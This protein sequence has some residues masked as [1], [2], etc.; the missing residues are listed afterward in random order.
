MQDDKIERIKRKLLNQDS[1]VGCQ[2]LYLQDEGYSNWTVEET[3]VI[4]ALNKNPQL[5]ANL[6]FDWNFR[7]ENQD[8]TK[9]NWPKT[10]NMTCDSYIE[11]GE[12]NRICFDVDGED[13]PLDGCKLAPEVIK[14]IGESSGRG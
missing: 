8:S 7:Y 6:P 2:Y 14:A 4:C 13:K 3:T 1:C 11:I 5:P 12:L 10:Q 9:D